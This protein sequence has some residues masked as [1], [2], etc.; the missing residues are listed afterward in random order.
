MLHTV[1]ILALGSLVITLLVGCGAAPSQTQLETSIDTP[2]EVTVE[3][4]PLFDGSRGVLSFADALDSVLPS[5]VRVGTLNRNPEGILVLGGI[6]SGAVIDAEKGY[7]LT[8]AHVVAGGDEFMITIPDGRVVSALLVGIDTPTDI[9]VLQADN[10]RVRSVS[11]G[12][13]DNL[14][15]GDLVFAVGYPLGLEESLSLGIISG[16]GRSDS[17]A[18]LQNFIQTDA[19]INTGNSGGPLLD[20]R[21]YLI[22]VNAAIVTGNGGN[23]GIA[24]SIPSNLAMQV[25][26]QLVTHGEVRRGA[27]GIEMT[28]VTEEASG[29]V[30]VNHW[31][32]ALVASVRAESA[33][34]AAGLQAG[35]VI[36]AFDGRKVKT[37]S[38]LRAWIGVATP[39]KPYALTYVRKA[40]IE[41]TVEIQVS[42]FKS[43]T[44]E[45]LEQLG[46]FVRP[47]RAEDNLPSN[48]IGVYISRV[49]E[50][51][52]ADRAGLQ[53]GDVISKVNSELVDSKH[54]CDR[55]V[56]ESKGRARLL[57]YRQGTA[58]PINIEP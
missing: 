36:I 9:A 50:N 13:S 3:G 27:I 7:I 49:A 29:R 54:I 32:G 52:P 40:G 42:G 33:A 6:G 34:E 23:M 1:K 31:D 43:P 21:G 56:S 24:Y 58:M 44:V 47:T 16:L 25:T 11:I 48:V 53:A 5:V 51:S 30:G 17:N 45:S 19:A 12:D 41:T 10:L 37:P 46:A 15:V 26:D 28:N 39:G 2:V 8:N 14:R 4:F 35:D 55:L 22:G 38:T 20:S 57:V 18:S